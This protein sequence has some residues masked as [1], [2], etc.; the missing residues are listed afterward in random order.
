MSLRNRIF[1]SA[2]CLI[3]LLASAACQPREKVPEATVEIMSFTATQ[4]VTRS[5]LS[6]QQMGGGRNT[7]PLGIK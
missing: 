3:M 2:V 4:T 7:Y 6:D 5:V 1:G